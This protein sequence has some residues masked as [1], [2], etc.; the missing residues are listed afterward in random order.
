MTHLWNQLALCE[1]KWRDKDD[2]SDYIA[3]RDSLRLAK[4]L[5]AIQDEFENT[6]AS[7]LHR[8]P[9]PSLESALSELVSEETR[10]STMKLHTSEMVMAT[11]SS[12]RVHL[13]LFLPDLPHLIQIS[14]AT[15]VRNLATGIVNAEK[16][17]L[18]GITE[19]LVIRLPLSLILIHHICLIMML[20]LH[21]NLVLF[22]LQKSRLLFIRFYLSP[23]LIPP[24]P[25]HQV[26]PLGI[27]ILLA[28]IT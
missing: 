19:L 26:I 4:F 9:L 13:T 21:P 6:W 2:A 1:P 14:S 24:C 8:S 7:L 3:F 17:F 28:V 15:T 22:L 16:G 27:L 23:L 18:V 11:A 25:P 12:I 10:F 20:H 5:T